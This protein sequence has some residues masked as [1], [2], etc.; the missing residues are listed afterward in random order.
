MVKTLDAPETQT[1]HAKLLAARSQFHQT[2]IVKTGKNSFNNS[3]Y[4]QLEDFLPFALKALAD[5]GLLGLVSFDFEFAR[6]TIYDVETGDTLEIK[7]PMSTANLKSCHEVQNLGA[8]QSYERRYLWMALFEVMEGEVLEQIP[9]TEPTR[10]MAT[11]EQI[12][13]LYDYAETDLMTD[14]QKLWLEKA[15]DRIT[16]DQAQKALDALKKLE[17]AET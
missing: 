10:E 14:G 4:F 8:V 2:P 5:N 15:N 7:S 12:S 16:A 6:L 11:P 9:A 17:E 3:R 13:A 1:I